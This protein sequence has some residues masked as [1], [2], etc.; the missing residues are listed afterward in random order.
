MLIRKATPE[1]LPLIRTLERQSETAAH[2]GQREYEALF[3]ANAPS[4]LVIVAADEAK[5]QRISGFAVVRCGGDEDEWEIENVVVA[6]EQRRQGVGTV[7]VEE[8]LR[9]A[10]D[11]QTPRVLLEVRESNQAARFLYEKLGFNEIGRRPGYY[12]DP[13]E[14]ALVLQISITDL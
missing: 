8:I 11:R 5:P 14:S 4:R 6:A 2:W 9:Q 7:L 3:A 1:D 10:R 12:Q 13:P